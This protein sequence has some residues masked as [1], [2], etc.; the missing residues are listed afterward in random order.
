MSWSDVVYKVMKEYNSKCFSPSY[1]EVRKDGEID[2]A[3][4]RRWD[5][6]LR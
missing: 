3:L 2:R 6:G 4:K 5:S 1:L